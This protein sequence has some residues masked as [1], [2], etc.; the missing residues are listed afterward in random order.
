MA[1]YTYA[2][3][4]PDDVYE[5][6]EHTQDELD[7][8]AVPLDRR[9]GCKNFYAEFKKC[10]AVQHQNNTRFKT[11]RTKGEDHCGYYF[12]HWAWCREVKAAEAGVSGRM[13]SL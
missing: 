8:M 3:R 2:I 9:D 13:N 10:I 11:W 7:A 1:F 12:D 4:V 6:K 5:P